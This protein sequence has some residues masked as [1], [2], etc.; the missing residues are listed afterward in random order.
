MAT[1]RTKTTD[2]TLARAGNNGS[3]TYA[4][5]SRTDS[6]TGFPTIAETPAISRMP[7]LAETEGTSTKYGSYKQ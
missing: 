4:S 6:T 2:G 3:S 1:A 5:N 7:E